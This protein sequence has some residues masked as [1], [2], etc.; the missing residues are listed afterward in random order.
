MTVN[1]SASAV[2]GPRTG[3]SHVLEWL[4][5]SAVPTTFWFINQACTKD[6]ILYPMQM[7]AKTF[8]I[9]CLAQLCKKCHLDA[10]S[11]CTLWPADCVDML[12]ASQASPSIFLN[13]HLLL[14]KCCYRDHFGHDPQNTSM[15]P[16]ALLQL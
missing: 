14:A 3:C 8:A 7:S 2:I 11:F 12:G 4:L 1:I 15:A 9:S 10:F 16:A 6:S 13:K 5:S